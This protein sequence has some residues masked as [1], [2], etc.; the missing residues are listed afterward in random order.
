MNLYD[1]LCGLQNIPNAYE[2][3]RD[4]R[5]Y[6]TDYLLS[7]LESED[8][9]AILGIGKGCDID[10]KRIQFKVKQLTLIDRNGEA[11]EAALDHY[12]LVGKSNVQ[13]EVKDLIGL[14]DEDYRQYAA[15]LVA[16]IREK[17]MATQVEDLAEK[18]L[19]EIEK[20]V[21]QITLAKWEPQCF[22]VVITIGLHSQLISMIEWIWHVILETLGQ[23]EQEVRHYIM[24]LND[25][26][27]RHFNTACL[28]AVGKKWIMG[29]E[30][31]RKGYNGG[32]QG[33]A[34]ALQDIEI[35]RAHGQLRK[36]S[37]IT[38]EWPFNVAQQKIYEMHIQCDRMMMYHY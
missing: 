1:Q 25:E 30:S 11:M 7:E 36:Q 15:N 3:W 21:H 17:G 9:V 13:C 35:R 29:C 18:A 26:L 22:D 19:K 2:M 10:L 31:A 33:A 12:G 23:E 34:Q 6:L 5:E 32:V 20:L 27:I 37:E 16:A 38:L 28:Q 14:K 4:Y 24:T 8:R